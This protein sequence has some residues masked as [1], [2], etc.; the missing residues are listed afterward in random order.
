MVIDNMTKG[1]LSILRF[2][3][4]KWMKNAKRGGRKKRSLFQNSKAIRLKIRIAFFHCGKTQFFVKL[5]A[6]QNSLAKP[7]STAAPIFSL[8]L[9]ISVYGIA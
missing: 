2:R 6:Y 1:L 9:E 5:T 8:R 7:C 3:Q 4:G